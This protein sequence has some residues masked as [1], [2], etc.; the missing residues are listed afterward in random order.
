M[1]IDDLLI[2]DNKG[3]QNIITQC[4]KCDEF[5]ADDNR[6]IKLNA[7]D[8]SMVYNMYLVSHSYCPSCFKE[9]TEQI[10]YRRLVK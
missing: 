9:E 8:V 10:K 4:C 5:K 2:K 6:Y 7:A 3:N 1:T